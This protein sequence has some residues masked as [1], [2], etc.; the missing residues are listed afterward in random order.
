[1]FKIILNDENV[2][3]PN[4]NIYYIVGRDGLY[5]YKKLDILEACTKVSK[6][7]SLETVKPY[8]KL[9]I[10]KIPEL[11]VK[12]VYTFLLEVYD[13]FKSEAV[14]MLFYNKNSK[15]FLIRVPNQEVSH[16]SVKCSY[17]ITIPN[18]LSIG[19]IHSHSDFGAF[20]SA[21]DKSDEGDF[22][23]LHITFGNLNNT[24]ISISAEAVSN[25]FRSK[26]DPEEYLEGLTKIDKHYDI[27]LSEFPE[28]WIDNVIETKP[29]EFFSNIK[30][31]IP[32]DTDIKEYYIPKHTRKHPEKYNR[33][34]ICGSLDLSHPEPN[35]I[36]GWDYYSDEPLTVG[37]DDEILY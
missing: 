13:R 28:D 9:N 34:P 16:S 15:E 7:P 23:G 12:R 29:F 25:G 27:Q 21:T 36:I 31:Q 2:K 18:Y 33:C 17:K 14:V 37:D 26:C 24:N 30:T 4:E 3:H 6:I 1:M 22:D 20:H 19:T 8:V 5:L 10:P 11:L 32:S 35:Y